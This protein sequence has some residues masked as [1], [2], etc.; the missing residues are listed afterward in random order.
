MLRV[1][2]FLSGLLFGFGLL[3]SGLANPA[4]VMAFLDLA[5]AW[6]PSLALVMAAAIGV[7][8][9][10]FTLAKRRARSV[11]G[12][13]VL[14]PSRRD[15]DRPLI[16]GSLIFGAGWGVAGICPGPA[17]ALLGSGYWQAYVFIAALLAGSFGYELLR[18]RPAM[19][20]TAQI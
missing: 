15:L 14:L 4:K 18:R 13:P 19:A 2:A 17:V 11:L 20:A 5:G 7:A 1:T 16:I 3:I 12:A 8:L 9:I 6:D 10:P